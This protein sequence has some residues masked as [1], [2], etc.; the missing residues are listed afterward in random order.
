MYKILIHDMDILSVELHQV[1]LR[2]NNFTDAPIRQ[3]S[4]EIR[5]RGEVH[6]DVS[7]N[8]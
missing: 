2:H 8:F 5:R 7:K 3:K 4:Y 6:L 1:L